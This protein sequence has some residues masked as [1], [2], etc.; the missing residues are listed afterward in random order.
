MTL[1]RALSSFRPSSCAFF[2]AVALE[3]VGMESPRILRPTD[4]FGALRLRGPLPGER[5]RCP[6][7]LCPELHLNAI[8]CIKEPQMLKPL[9]V[10]DRSRNAQF[11]VCLCDVL[12]NK[13]SRGAKRLLTPLL[14]SS[15]WEGEDI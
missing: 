4:L 9:F 14:F 11:G 1:H 15:I 13:I 8:R 2:G 12:T 10:A 6:T 7:L 5:G 3:S